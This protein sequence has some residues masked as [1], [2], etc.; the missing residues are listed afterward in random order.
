MGAYKPE[1]N[2]FKSKYDKNKKIRAIRIRMF[3]RQ[4]D[5]S[6]RNRCSQEVDARK[7][8]YSNRLKE[9]ECKTVEEFKEVINELKYSCEVK[10][11]SLPRSLL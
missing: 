8:H 4:F 1:V 2:D 11:A 3:G 6:C 10:H 9:S 7:K 5:I